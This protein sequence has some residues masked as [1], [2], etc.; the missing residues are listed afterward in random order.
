MRWAMRILLLL[1]VAFILSLIPLAWLAVSAY[2]KYRGKRVIT[3]PETRA[4][5]AVELDALHAVSSELTGSVDLRLQSCSRWPEREGC[6][7]ECLAQIEAAPEDCL[8]RTM[9]T[10]WY[11]GAACVLCGRDIGE[12]RWS[13]RK[14]A[15]MSPDRK[16]LEWDE[17]PPDELPSVLATH[18]RICWDC[19]IAESFRARHPELVLDD[20]L[21]RAARRSRA[22]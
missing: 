12:I 19:H 7:Q 14:P 15:L 13:E 16:T 5:A 18:Y 11:R 3:C 10:K 22:S 1:A 8:V 9:L 21:H 2:R 20:P 4:P 17:V 6:G